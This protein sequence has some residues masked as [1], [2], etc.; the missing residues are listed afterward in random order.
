MGDS[1]KAAK[2]GALVLGILVASYGV[3]RFV[4]ESAGGGDEYPVHAF[5]VDA[6][7]LVQKSRVLIAGIQVG[8]IEGIS[9]DG[10]RARVD[11]KI[12]REIP[13]YQGARVKKVAASI[14]GE[15]VLVI[16][17]GNPTGEPLQEG[18]ELQVDGGAPST[19]DILGTVGRITDSVENIAAQV[20]RVFGTDEGGDQMASALKNLS[21]AL[22]AIN[23]TIQDNRTVVSNTLSN[24]EETTAVA[25]P[26]LLR[27]LDNVESTTADVRQIIG[28]NRDGLTEAGG[29]VGETV[30][31]LRVA[32]ESLERVMEDVEEVTDRTARGEGTIGRL[33]QDEALIDE[34][35]GV[36]RDIGDFVGPIARLQTIVGLRS[37]YNFLANTFKNYVSIRL[38]PREDRYY[39]IQLVDDPRG[40]SD[41]VQTTVRRSPP[42]DGEPAVYQETRLETRE[43]FR[44]SLLFAKRLYFA[45]LRFGIIESVGGIGLDLHLF[46]DRFE[47]NTDLFAFGSE[48]F[49][50]LRFR[51]AFEVV[52]KLFV[53]AG[54]DDT[55]N[56]SRDFFLGAQLRFNDEDLKSILPFAG[57]I[58][59]GN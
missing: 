45:T 47:L 21:Q 34:V 19:D 56:E 24:V 48:T 31:N 59:V 10:Q 33:T 51:L 16:A 6:Q 32:S 58:G 49:P 54:L 18:A 26:Q 42:P 57:G 29:D 11:L 50:R 2:V 22:E 12:N 5:F 43:D 44:F 35:Q 38:Q 28:Q 4:D 52:Q 14:L 15:S 30:A 41:F 40:L 3:F 20:E 23:I 7:G 53:L 39:L 13:L 27:I 46:D 1:I 25:G 8:Y 37:E 17:P 55:L 36:A 9:L